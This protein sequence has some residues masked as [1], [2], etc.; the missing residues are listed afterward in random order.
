MRTA[1]KGKIFPRPLRR[2]WNRAKRKFLPKEQLV[3]IQ[4]ELVRDV[5]R[6]DMVEKFLKSPEWRDLIGPW[7]WRKKTDHLNALS[8]FR[9]TY[10]ADTAGYYEGGQI[11]L[12]FDLRQMLKNVIVKRRIALQKLEKMQA[13][14]ENSNGR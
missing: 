5:E 3:Q 10:P 2:V 6:G 7:L 11:A 9:R 12:V 8:Q 4:A 13:K 1:E 14:P